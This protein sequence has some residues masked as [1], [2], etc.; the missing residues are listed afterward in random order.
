MVTKNDKAHDCCNGD[1]GILYIECA[2]PQNERYS[3]SLSNYRCPAWEGA[4]GLENLTL[5]YAITV[6]KSQDGEVDT[7][8]MP[9][10][11]QFQR[12]MYPNL[13][14]TAISRA[15]KQVVLYGDLNA[16]SAAVQTSPCPRKSM[17]VAKTRMRMMKK[18]VGSAV[19]SGSDWV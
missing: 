11:R 4:E 8:L 2:E 19:L 14:Y 3:I 12:M 17:L 7:M 13:L 1:V 16:L 6:H 5:A 18:A 15:R 9:M 10:T